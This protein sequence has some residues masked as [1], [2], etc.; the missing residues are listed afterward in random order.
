MKKIRLLTKRD[1]RK[2]AKHE[3]QQNSI[4][5]KKF[6]IHSNEIEI[7]VLRFSSYYLPY[8]ETRQIVYSYGAEN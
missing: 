2:C 6:L 4:F 7:L 3:I 5:F 1:K 8:F